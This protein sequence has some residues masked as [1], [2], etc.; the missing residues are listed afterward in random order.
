VKEV[1][2]ISAKPRIYDPLL[3]IRI[4]QKPQISSWE[5]MEK[6]ITMLCF[7]I[8]LDLKVHTPMLTLVFVGSNR[9]QYPE[10]F[11]TLQ[12]L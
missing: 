8:L 11:R 10:D 12:L 3:P 9:V 1:L 5:L 2:K 6:G 4:H 7:Q